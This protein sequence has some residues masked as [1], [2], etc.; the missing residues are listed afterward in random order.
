VSVAGGEESGRGEDQ[1]GPGHLL[2][3]RPHARSPQPAAQLLGVHATM[4]PDE[5]RQVF[6][7][8]Y[9]EPPD[10]PATAAVVGILESLATR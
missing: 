6:A 4:L 9:G 5:T 10:P 3:A 7:V 2:D 8:T 1:H